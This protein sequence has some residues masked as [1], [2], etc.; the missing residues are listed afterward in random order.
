MCP[1]WVPQM[2]HSFR[3]QVKDVC[4]REF[5]VVINSL[6]MLQ[7]DWLK[8]NHSFIVPFCISYTVKL[9]WGGWNKYSPILSRQCVIALGRRTYHFFHLACHI[10]SSVMPP[11]RWLAGFSWT[12]SWYTPDSMSSAL[13]KRTSWRSPMCA[14]TASSPTWLQW[15]LRKTVFVFSVRIP[16]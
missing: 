8:N 9:H 7:D 2:P 12:Q 4:T 6:G 13:Q 1:S 3:N 15:K 5:L 14:R 16:S 10:P 11:F